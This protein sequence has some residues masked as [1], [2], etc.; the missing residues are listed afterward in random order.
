MSGARRVWLVGG[1]AAAACFLAAL[2]PAPPATP[3][4]DPSAKF[5]PA[6]GT[7]PKYVRWLEERSMLFQA[8]EQARAL[9]GSSAQWRHPFA[10]PQPRAAVRR[11]PVWLLDY[12][13][14]VIPRPGKSVLATWGDPELWKALR[15]IGIDLLH[16]GP[17][18]RAGG[19]TGY[20]YT[21][22]T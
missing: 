21:P 3:G 4:G 17:V 5:G 14:S 18:K 6:A 16:T 12:A 15:E 7:N 10:R 20:E 2:L 13:G 22:S 8:A 1:A 11:A 19:I 9:S